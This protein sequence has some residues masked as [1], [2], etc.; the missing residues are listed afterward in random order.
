MNKTIAMSIGFILF[1]VGMLAVVLSLVGVQLSFLV[2]LDSISTLFGFV[3]KLL[4]VVG[5]IVII[6]LAQTDWS[7]EQ[8]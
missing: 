4:M 6:V 2:W 3:A 8:S 7:Q 1:I 5:G